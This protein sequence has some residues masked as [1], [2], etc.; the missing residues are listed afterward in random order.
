VVNGV[1]GKVGNHTIMLQRAVKASTH[2]AGVEATWLKCLPAMRENKPVWNKMEKD[3][4]EVAQI[5]DNAAIW[6]DIAKTLSGL[7]PKMLP[8]FCN[9]A[10]CVIVSACREVVKGS[11]QWDAGTDGL[12]VATVDQHVKMCEHAMAI[13]PSLTEFALHA[14]RLKRLLNVLGSAAVKRD[15]EERAI[16][17][18]KDLSSLPELDKLMKVMDM[19]NGVDLRAPSERIQQACDVATTSVFNGDLM[20]MPPAKAANAFEAFNAVAS[21][22]G[23]TKYVSTFVVQKAVYELAVAHLE[24]RALGPTYADIGGLD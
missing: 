11:L 2:W 20:D 17:Y 13:D 14:T 3:A 7:I 15:V 6:S 5:S 22:A 24:F 21:A 4:G 9:G 10:K 16:E 23:A 1:P 12:L 19:A 18:S 8:G